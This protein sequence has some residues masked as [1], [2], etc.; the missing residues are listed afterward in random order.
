MQIWRGGTIGTIQGKSNNTD[1]SL[2]QKRSHGQ[3]F[4]F[5]PYQSPVRLIIES[6]VGGGEEPNRG[7]GM[8]CYSYVGASRLHLVAALNHAR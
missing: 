2:S 7:G 6:T 3:N 5:C 8:G 4:I 1:V